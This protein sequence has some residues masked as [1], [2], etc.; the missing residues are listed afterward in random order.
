MKS[1]LT[2]G[3]VE[4]SFEIGHAALVELYSRAHGIDISP[5]LGETDPI[6]C[7]RCTD[8]GFEFFAPA[9]LAGPREFYA[10]LYR[11]SAKANWG[12]LESKWDYVA[13]EQFVPETGR[14]LDIGCGGGDFLAYLGPA[15]DRLGLETSPFGLKLCAEKGIPTVDVPI[16]RLSTDGPEPFDT[17]VALQVLEHVADPMPFLRA[18]LDV[19][20]PGGTLVIVVPN[21]DAFLGSDMTLPLN[22]PPHH[23]GRWRR[24]ALEAVAA[25]LGVEL[26][27]IEC[28]P[29]SAA[30]LGWYQAWFETRYLRKGRLL[31]SL[32]YRLGFA[33]AFQ[34]FL[35]QQHHTLMGHSI[36]A[37]YRKPAD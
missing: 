5:Y 27:R 2:G 15:R 18:A 23:M 11:D 12:Y 28:E 8:T 32:W 29:L 14:V 31:R 22:L 20:R 9:E 33:A 10:D 24:Q 21:N 25:H 37:A 13:A 35:Q 3:S 36:L 16:E 4:P 19:T 6:R 17:V 30:N 26:L 1:P 7:F 34:A